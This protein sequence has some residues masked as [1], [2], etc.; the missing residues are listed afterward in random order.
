LQ[1]HNGV[2]SKFLS[3]LKNLL[4]VIVTQCVVY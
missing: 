1:K 2:T 4:K 3:L